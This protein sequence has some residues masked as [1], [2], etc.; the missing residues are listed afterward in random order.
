L[1][2]ISRKEITNKASTKLKL[3]SA[4][5]FGLDL[6]TL[7]WWLDCPQSQMEFSRV[8]PIEFVHGG[9]WARSRSL[10]S[11]RW[12]YLG[13][14]VIHGRAIGLRLGVPGAVPMRGLSDWEATNALACFQRLSATLIQGAC[15][16]DGA[17]LETMPIIQRHAF[18]AA[19][20]S[21]KL[22]IRHA[23]LAERSAQLQER[24]AVLAGKAVQCR[25]P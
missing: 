2:L 25:R 1:L 21:G 9:A 18:C 14:C 4:P 3:V 20:E 8:G 5:G 16:L 17:L 12:P 13:Q 24:K 22:A 19:D 15:P 6:A 23:L 7:A 10:E 11:L